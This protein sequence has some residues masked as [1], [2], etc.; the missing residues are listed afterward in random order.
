[1]PPPPQQQPYGSVPPPPP[2][3]S[4]SRP[5]QSYGQPYYGNQQPTYGSPV[6]QPAMNQWNSPPQP[7]Q[8]PAANL[9]QG[10]NPAQIQSMIQLL[11]SQQ[12]GG[13]PPQGIT[14]NLKDLPQIAM[15]VWVIIIIIIIIIITDQ[16][17]HQW[18]R[19]L[20]D[21]MT[22]VLIKFKHY[23]L[24]CNPINKAILMDSLLPKINRAKVVL[25]MTPCLG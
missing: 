21:R 15:E 25:S 13:Q 11:Q 14:D 16:M 1:M 5:P 10:L 3:S 4:S 17:P 20:R 2:Q 18:L 6:Q 19:N 7:P 12:Q 8:N 24:N 9:L 23:L 22:I